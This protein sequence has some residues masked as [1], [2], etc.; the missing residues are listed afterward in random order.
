MASTR[1]LHL[2]STGDAIQDEITIE[3]N[4]L[5]V[6]RQ[7]RTQIEAAMY[8]RLL[9]EAKQWDQLVLPGMSRRPWL[10]DLLPSGKVL[11]EDARQSYFV[12]LSEVRQR[13]GEYLGMLSSN[14]RQQIRR[15]IRAFETLG[16]LVLTEASD[17]D[18]AFNFLDSLSKLHERRWTAKGKAGSFADPLFRAFHTRLVRDTFAQG[19][20]QLIRVQAGAHDVGYL[21]SFVHR[22]H[23]SFYQ[24][25]FDCALLGAKRKPGM[26]THYL[27][28]LHNARLGNAIYDFLAGAAQYKRSLSSSHS[29]MVWSKVHRRTLAYRIEE[30]LRAAK[31]RWQ[32]LRASASIEPGLEVSNPR[33]LDR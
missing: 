6:Q 18:S 25:G 19:G 23:V 27:S 21:Y 20:I 12:D 33:P 2:H 16:P 7:G 11:Q 14:T 32:A 24:S 31:R 5:L 22:G 9:L 1:C 28:V 17:L 30:A 29:H 15:S 26:V 3:H 13:N 8:A 4:G 10:T